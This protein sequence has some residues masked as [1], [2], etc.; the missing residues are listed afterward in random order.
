MSGDPGPAHAYVPSSPGCWRVFGEVQ[1]DEL[2]RFGYPPAH[3][4]VVDAYM[5]Q[6]P[7][8]G[9]DRRARQS[10][11]VHLLALCAVLEHDATPAQRAAV[12]RGALAGPPDFPP[13]PRP[14]HPA[15]VTVLRMVGAADLD[16]YAARAHEWATAVWTSWAGHH[17][18]IR[19][20]LE[21]LRGER[22]R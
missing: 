13:L 2:A 8:D 1:A 7:G 3:G 9:H 21:R 14:T 5:A 20:R 6:H 18:A 17:A 4:L 22:S 19:D 15:S 16:D 10:V 11:V 12:M